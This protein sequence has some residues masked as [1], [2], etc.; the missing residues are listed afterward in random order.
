MHNHNPS[1][2]HAKIHP[3]DCRHY[4]QMRIEKPSNVDRYGVYQKITE[5]EQVVNGLGEQEVTYCGKCHPEEIELVPTRK[6]LP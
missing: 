4:K 3:S 2:R 1:H 5:A 6:L